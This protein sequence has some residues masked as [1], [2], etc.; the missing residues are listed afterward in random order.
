MLAKGPVYA[1]REAFT[2]LRSP[3]ITMLSFAVLLS[4]GHDQSVIGNLSVLN[5]RF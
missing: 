2:I 3:H 4:C 5:E 1:K